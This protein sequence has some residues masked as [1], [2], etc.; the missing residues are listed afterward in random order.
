MMKTCNSFEFLEV[1]I[2]IKLDKG[3]IIYKMQL[4]LVH[5]ITM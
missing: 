1:K 4:L 3:R 5:N 2:L